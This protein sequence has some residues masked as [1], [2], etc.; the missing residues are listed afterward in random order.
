MRPEFT[1]EP[2]ATQRVLDHCEKQT[3]NT[4]NKYGQFIRIAT[5]YYAMRSIRRKHVNDKVFTKAF[6][7]QFHKYVALR[8]ELDKEATYYDVLNSK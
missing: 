7:K 5:K 4:T 2:T 8:N 1:P 3:L 6:R